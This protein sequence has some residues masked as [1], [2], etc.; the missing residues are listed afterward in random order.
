MFKKVAKDPSWDKYNGL[1]FWNI[2]LIQ[3]YYMYSALAHPELMVTF[4]LSSTCRIG[5]NISLWKQ[6]AFNDGGRVFGQRK[7]E[8]T[9]TVPGQALE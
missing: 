7:A 1:I 8:P 4:A 9:F 6:I 3:N 5:N 2:M